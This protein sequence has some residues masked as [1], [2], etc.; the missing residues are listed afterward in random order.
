MV[1]MLII[2]GITLATVIILFW[3][4]RRYRSV[5]KYCDHVDCGH[6]QMRR[7]WD[8]MM[9]RIPGMQKLRP[10]SDAEKCV[11]P[12]TPMGPR[13]MDSEREAEAAAAR[14]QRFEEELRRRESRR[15][16]TKTILAELEGDLGMTSEQALPPMPPMPIDTES[17]DQVPELAIKRE[18][19]VGQGQQVTVV[20]G[21]DAA[22]IVAVRKGTGAGHSA[23]SSRV[24]SERDL[25]PIPV[26]RTSDDDEDAP[27]PAILQILYVKGENDDDEN[28]F[29]RSI[30]Q[31][32]PNDKAAVVSP[33]NKSPE[34]GLGFKKGD[35]RQIREERKERLRHK[36]SQRSL[37]RKKLG[38]AGK[39]PISPVSS[40]T[41]TE[42][43]AD[44]SCV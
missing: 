43:K 39:D 19:M 41:E 34:A 40:M 23:A 36:R 15:K 38:S 2:A 26:H 30:S 5:G 24:I 18:T 22:V 20:K 33:V 10:E 44:S 7:K 17:R 21:R 11:V 1:E 14:R 25:P 31:P 28:E 3:I 37:H 27:K 32:K 13:V 16:S 4:W 6:S 35:D 8:S 9:G 42:R 29:D 12:N